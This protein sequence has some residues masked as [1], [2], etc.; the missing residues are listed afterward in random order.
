MKA[1]G[2]GAILKEIKTGGSERKTPAVHTHLTAF[3]M[4]FLSPLLL[5][6]DVHSLLA[7]LDFIS[8]F[9]R[10]CPHEIVIHEQ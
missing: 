1:G 7:K 4:Y 2:G 9:N 10:L 5:F 8:H 6:A 3:I